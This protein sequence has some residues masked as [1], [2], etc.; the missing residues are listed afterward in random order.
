[1]QYGLGSLSYPEDDEVEVRN[2]YETFED[3]RRGLR[4]TT[5]TASY[6]FS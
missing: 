2:F 4:Q 6:L 5:V 1:M 3:R